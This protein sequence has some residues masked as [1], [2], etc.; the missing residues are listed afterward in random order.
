MF[1][2]EF[3]DS[4]EFETIVVTDEEGNDITLIILDVSEKDGY[5]YL[6]VADETS[7][8]DDIEDETDVYI[9]KGL[10]TD[11][12]DIHYEFV[13]DEAELDSLTTLFQDEDA[14][15]DLK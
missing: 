5:S 9:L 8:E 6:L 10:I 7:L 15:Y 13:E 1:N 11:E 3:Y 14:D 4:E 12:E 2:E